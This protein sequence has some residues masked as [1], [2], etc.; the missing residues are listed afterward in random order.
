VVGVPPRPIPPVHG[1]LGIGLPEADGPAE[2]IR[3]FPGSGAQ[4]AGLQEK[5]VITQINDAPLAKRSEVQS[6]LRQLRPGTT[7]KLT[8]K[9]GDKVLHVTATMSLLE[10]EASKKRDAQNLAKPTGVSA[11]RDDFPKV[12]QHDA[13]L[14]PTDCG[15]PLADLSGRVI[16]LNIAR[17]GRTETYAVPSDVVVGLMY[18]LMSGRLA[19]KPAPK[20]EPK[21]EP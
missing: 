12:V 17:G 13:V 7:V 6:R 21:P 4:K 3:V 20:P 2:I 8:V 19:P 10:T 1:M 14:L 5:D 18:D 9:R 15:G 16:G 11:R